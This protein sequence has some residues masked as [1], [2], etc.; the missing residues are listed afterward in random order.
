MKTSLSP[1]AIGFSRIFGLVDA[2]ALGLSVNF[3]LIFIGLG[4]SV[5]QI[6][7]SEM[8]W[9]FVVSTILFLPLLFSI[10][11]RAQEAPGS[12]SSYQLSRLS[13]PAWVVFL[14]GWLILAGHISVAAIFASL[15]GQRISKIMAR[16]F[17]SQ[18]D[19]L[20]VLIPML[21]LAAVNEFIKARN[22]T[23]SRNRTI[24]LCL[25]ALYGF[26]VWVLLFHQPEKATLPAALPSR[27]LLSS[28]AILAAGLWGFDLVTSARRQLRNPDKTLPMAL[29]IIILL[30]NITCLIAILI[31]FQFPDLTAGNILQNLNWGNAQFS[32]I[33]ILVTLVICWIGLSRTLAS[34]MRL[35]G[36]MLD[37][38]FFPRL[39]LHDTLTRSTVTILSMLFLVVLLLAWIDLPKLVIGG[40]AAFCWLLVFVLVMAPHIRTARS[41]LSANRHLKLPL[42][43]LIP[44]TASVISLYLIA[45]LPRPSLIAGLLLIALG[46]LYYRLYG[47]RGNVEVQRKKSVVGDHEAL[48]QKGLFRV[49]VAIKPQKN[50]AGNAALIGLGATVAYAN[51]GELLVLYARPVEKLLS[52]ETT[53]VRAENDW[54]RLEAAVC[55][56][57][58]VKV[59]V[60]SLIRIAPDESVAI[61]ETAKEYR[62]D[63]ILLGAPVAGQD[64]VYD[65]RSVV[66]QV[67]H[68]A[69]C[70]VAVFRGVSEPKP[71]TI[72]V[73]A[74]ERSNLETGLRFS[75]AFGHDEAVTITLLTNQPEK[76][77]ITIDPDNELITFKQMVLDG[78]D[79][80]RAIGRT[81]ADYDLLVL[82]AA[83]DP[84]QS[85]VVLDG[86]PIE[87]M[88]DKKQPATVI[89]KSAAP[90]KTRWLRSLFQALNDLLPTLSL[91]EQSDVF[92]AL[93]RSARANID[94]YML[95]LLSSTIATLGL[96]LN[97]GAVI[98]GAMLVAPLM[99][100]I[101][102]IGNGIVLGNFLLMQ[103]G[104]NAALNGIATVIAVATS[105]VIF[106]P[107]Q[108]PGSEILARSEPNMFDLLVALAAG[109]TA[110]Y[111][112]SRKS[113]SAALPGVAIAVALVPPLCVVGYGLGVARFNIAGGALLLFATNFA[114]IIMAGAGVFYLMGF[115]PSR[116]TSHAVVRRALTFAIIGL[117]IIIIPLGFST[118]NSLGE[119]QIQALIT[120]RF[121]QNSDGGHD[122]LRDIK[123]I[124]RDDHY[125]VSLTI[126]SIEDRSGLTK[127]ISTL[128]HYLEEAVESPVTID[129]AAVKGYEFIEGDVR[130]Q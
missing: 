63:H 84:L 29:F 71:G 19:L 43:P 93:S 9:V 105:F 126:Y 69:S 39:T 92:A 70:S 41:A 100:P 117:L 66:D 119:R 89:I 46:V 56:V 97:S 112:I 73:A 10:A 40:I 26:F 61:L 62:V 108:Q 44:L 23:L 37:D 72:L 34:S 87:P 77:D 74:T 6:A 103:R 59:P 4:L 88:N 48:P 16:L 85:Q 65:Q 3:G 67:F 17:D 127:R 33:I 120:E 12:A 86:F 5:Y 111:G 102:A 78:S 81:A 114:A 57:K 75:R 123:V 101:L 60:R 2:I 64:S 25:L 98:I 30:V 13:S 79:L 51:S 38:G 121:E 14:T 54:Q 8:P 32:F 104:L 83:A 80:K 106:L 124:H 113:V 95:I 36:A 11:E 68:R 24:W 53:R 49:L 47:F 99:N 90:S 52:P 55:A 28:V 94:Y 20:W 35:V 15:I 125:R 7:G 31:I 129:V 82:G 116:S 1:R 18:V 110:A 42:H 109:M 21:A 58:D 115:R 50:T 128:R 45:L 22:R 130:S 76:S 96:I 91:T 27:N 107:E 122:R 118:R